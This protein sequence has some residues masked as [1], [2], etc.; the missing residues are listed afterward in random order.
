M[1]DTTAHT[2]PA[3]CAAAIPAARTGS[4]QAVRVCQSSDTVIETPDLL[5]AAN[6]FKLEYSLTVEP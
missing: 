6:Q 1:V 4:C 2:C 3:A 5:F